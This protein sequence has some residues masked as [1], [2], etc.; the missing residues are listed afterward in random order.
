MFAFLHLFNDIFVILSCQISK[1]EERKKNI[2]TTE[3]IKI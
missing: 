3:K 2:T 1:K